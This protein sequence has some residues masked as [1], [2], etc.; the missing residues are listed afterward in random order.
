MKDKNALFWPSYS[1]LMTNLFFIM[2]V[3]FVLTLVIMNGRASNFKE[4]AEKS[5]S[6]IA[7]IDSL[8]K[9][10]QNIDSTY[11]QYDERYK[12]H[13]LKID[14][15]YG[16]G[17]ADIGKLPAETRSKLCDAGETIVSFLRRTPDTHYLLVIEGQA[18]KDGYAYN[19][20]LSYE[21]ALG[22]KR[23]WESKGI[24]FGDNC[25]VLVSGSGTGGIMRDMV[26]ERNNQRFLI[27]I[28]P[29]PGMFKNESDEGLVEK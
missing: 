15:A 1:D 28:M 29:K 4:R 7:K 22:L 27:H 26:Y 14:V 17:K 6:E 18:S 21:R 11:F 8:E 5:E 24:T 25:E 23:F 16:V 3:L 13:R 2:L 20:Q 12:A 9:A 19:D 10:I